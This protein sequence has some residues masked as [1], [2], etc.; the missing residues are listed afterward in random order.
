MAPTESAP[1]KDVETALAA[2]GNGGVAAMPAPSKNTTVRMG[3]A[4]QTL[5]EAWRMANFMSQSD[6]VPK[7]YQRK[8]ADILVAIQ[9]GMELGFPPMQALQSIAVINGRPSVWGD[10]FLAL[11]MASALYK[12]HDEYFE[13]DGKKVTSVSPEDLK[14]ETTK[15]VCVFWRHGKAT[16]TLRDFSVSK[17]KT[18]KLWGKEGPWTNYPDVMLAARARG[19]AGRATFPDLL[20]GIKTAEEAI[21]DPLPPPDIDVVAEAPKEV[22]RV[23]E[24]KASP[25][26]TSETGDVVV[27]PIRVTQVQQLL[28]TYIAVLASGQQVVVPN[29]ADAAELEKFVGTDHAIRLV[30]VGFHDG[31]HA[32][33]SLKSFGIAD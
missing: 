6:L 28:G 21:D 3:L 30:C 19:F 15:A 24:T 33:L 23:S 17:A 1:V 16:P 7:Q 25:A 4:P 10:G 11:I 26:V 14:K 32:G 18:A 2:P 20:R 27:G 22:R 9:F 5:D 12:D 31:T 29:D 13:V 8:P